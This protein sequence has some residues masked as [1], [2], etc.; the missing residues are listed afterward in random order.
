[1]I[2]PA[3]RT[4]GER[5]KVVYVHVALIWTGM[6]GFTLAGLLGILMLFIE[7]KHWQKWNRVLSWVS[8][9]WFAGGVA[10]SILAAKVNWG[11]IYWQEPRMLSSLQFLAVATLVLVAKSLF[12][13]YRVRGTLSAVLAFLL[14]WSSLGVPHVVHPKNAILESSAI[15]IQLT[16]LA[17]FILS[18]LAAAC[19][20]G[21]FLKSE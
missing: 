20:L 12:P 1:M 5:I 7:K 2:A 6:L 21:Y 17:M 4:L 19:S 13:W 10:T 16:F 9:T 11:V 14:I 3:E 18:S 8:L 15:T